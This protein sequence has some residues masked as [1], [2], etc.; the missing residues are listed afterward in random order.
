ML[1]LVMSAAVS[2]A[3]APEIARDPVVLD[4]CRTLARRAMDERTREHGAFVVRSRDGL[5]YFVAWPPVEERHIL[6]WHGR[7]PEGTIAIVHT[8]EGWTPEPSKL[9]RKA[10]RGARIPVYVITPRQIAKTEGEEVEV[11]V[12]GDWMRD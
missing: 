10:A 7:F 6:R 1:A 8:H 12:S 3:S 5:L 4:F 2:L 11:V 9:D